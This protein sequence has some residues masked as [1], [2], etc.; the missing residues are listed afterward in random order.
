[1]WSICVWHKKD[2]PNGRHS[3]RFAWDW[4]RMP[5]GGPKMTD[6]PSSTTC[7]WT[8]GSGTIPTA[9]NSDPFATFSPRYLFWLTIT[10]MPSTYGNILGMGSGPA[11]PSYITASTSSSLGTRVVEWCAVCQMHMEKPRVGQGP[12]L[13]LPPVHTIPS[14]W[15]CQSIQPYGKESMLISVPG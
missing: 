13:Q 4:R 12:T 8:L 10:G 14:V 5:Q 15:P 1:M 2:L 9:V 11:S 6:R 7:S 3:S